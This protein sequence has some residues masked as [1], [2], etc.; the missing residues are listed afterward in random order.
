VCILLNRN[1][2]TRILPNSKSLQIDYA[3][4]TLPAYTHSMLYILSKDTLHLI[5]HPSL[6]TR[7]FLPGDDGENLAIWLFGFNLTPIHDRRIQEGE[8]IC[9]NDLIGKR[10]ERISDMSKMYF[11]VVNERPQCT[12]FDS[13][14]CAVCYSCKDKKLTWKTLNLACDMERG[15]TLLEMAGFD[16]LA[17]KKSY[18]R[19]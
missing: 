12:G 6:A 18:Y 11:N 3:L 13:S 9:E 14:N 2:P 19:V 16:Q 7:R 17:G 4:P 1:I 10:M 8:S 15:I 5:V